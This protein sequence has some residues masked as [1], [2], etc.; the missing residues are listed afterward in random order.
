MET[1]TIRRAS[2]DDLP[3]MM[4]A[5]RAAQEYMVK[6][7]N[8]DQWKPGFP[9]EEFI[10]QEIMRGVSYVLVAG[11]GE[12]EGA[13]SMVPGKDPTYSKVYGGEWLNDDPYC[14]IHKL[15]SRGRR[16]GVFDAVVSYAA[17][18]FDNIR[19]DTHEDNRTMRHL[20]AKAGFRQIGTILLANGSPRIAFHLI[21]NR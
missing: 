21:V 2:P 15:A 14:T 6:S 1:F 20:F 4:E 8:P 10:R 3:G 5:Y 17:G 19:A 11:D 12:I 18:I 9:P 16:K 13:F 7:G